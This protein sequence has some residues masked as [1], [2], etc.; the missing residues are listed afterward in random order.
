MTRVNVVPPKEL[1]NKHLFAEWR[2]MPRLVANL[3][4][5]LN[6]KSKPFSKTEISPVYKLGTGHVKFFFDKFKY[7][8][9][10][11]K[12]ITEELLMRGYSLSTT[13]SSIFGTVPNEYYQ[14]YKPTE[15][16]MNIN[17]ERIKIRMPKNP[18]FNHLKEK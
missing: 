16:A 2:E 11:H 18:K 7:L 1:C 14:D 15:D 3:Q 4:A 6:R 10:R 13:D 17:R 8:H 5:S 9:K 12:S